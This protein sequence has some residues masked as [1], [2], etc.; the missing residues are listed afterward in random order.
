MESTDVR[1][2]LVDALRLAFVGPMR[3]EGPEFRTPN[4]QS[5]RRKRLPWSDDFHDEVL[6]RLLELN[7]QRHQEEV[8]AGRV[9]E[10][11]TK[12]K[13]RLSSRKQTDD[14]NSPRLPGL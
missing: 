4:P 9:A 10:G 1:S 13:R 12:P 3:L 11:V 2:Q 14:S 5:R 6:A 8:L 7:E